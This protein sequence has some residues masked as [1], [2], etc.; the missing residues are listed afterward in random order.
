MLPKATSGGRPGLSFR[1]SLSWGSGGVSDGKNHGRT[2]LDPAFLP[3]DAGC[4]R[5]DAEKKSP[6][7][8]SLAIPHAAVHPAIVWP[9]VLALGGLAGF[10]GIGG[11]FWLCRR[12][13]G[14]SAFRWLKQWQPHWWSWRPWGYRPAPATPCPEGIDRDYVLAHRRRRSGG[15]VGWRSPSV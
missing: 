15:V 10:L 8:H 11:G 3:V 12:W 9:S 13:F 5:I 6:C 2:L 14:F 4:R 7:R 1:W